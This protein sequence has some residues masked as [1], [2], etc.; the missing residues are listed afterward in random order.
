MAMP[1]AKGLFHRAATMSGQQVTACGPL[2]GTKRAEA[3][4]KEAG[5]GIADLKTVSTKTLL[6]GL[7]AR[8]PINPA[9]G[10]YLG[11]VLDFHVLPRHPFFPDAPAQ[12]AHIPMMIGNTHDETR[13]F[14]QADWA[15]NLTWE[16]LP[17]RL[18]ENVRVDILPCV[19]IA[20]YKKLFPGITPSD[21]F[22]KAT[23]AGRSWRGAIEEVEARARAG[24][25]AFAYQVDWAMPGRDGKLYAPH[26]I[27]IPL[28]F[29]NTDK[30][31]AA[32]GDKEAARKMATVVS[33]TFIAFARTGT[34]NTALLPEWP[35]YDLNER[36]TMIFDLP[37]HLANDPRGTERRIFEKVPFIQ[38][39][40]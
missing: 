2:N 17:K 35:R 5:I 25:P 8:D 14:I 38:W 34:P 29:D 16:E 28:A 20:E 15:Y 10:L 27:D 19:V 18:A 40:T 21:L 30:P 24:C 23:T 3:F 9:M 39:G 4:L 37:P 13:A 22:F 31:G 33:E 26:A 36:A 11:P 12:S 1:A 32:T 7:K 6:K